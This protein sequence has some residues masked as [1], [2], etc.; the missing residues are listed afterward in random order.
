MYWSGVL[1]RV[2]G[3]QL[4]LRS[5]FLRSLTS[6]E[7]ESNPR[8]DVGSV[9]YWPL[10]YQGVASATTPVPGTCKPAFR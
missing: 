2:F 6:P 7:G 8:R 4:Q 1:K 3:L 9:A 5:L 10:Y